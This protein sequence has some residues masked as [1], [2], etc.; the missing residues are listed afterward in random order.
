MVGCGGSNSDTSSIATVGSS[1][2]TTPVTLS[3]SAYIRQADAICGES[4]A[5]INAIVPGST[6]GEQA[7]STSQEAAIIRNEISSL[8][9]L[10][11][12]QG[13]SPAQFIAAMQGIS[14]QLNR[15]RLA[16]QRGDE[17]V[18]PSITAALDDAE[19]KAQSLG[20][21]YG[22]KNCGGTSAPSGSPVAGG[23]G[24]ST[25]TTP[26]T[27]TPTTITPTTTP[28]AVTPPSGGSTPITPTT[29]PTTTTPGGGVSPGGGGV[30][31]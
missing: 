25:A 5:A 19:A 21:S 22:F 24:G 1:T 18:L 13:A 20:A 31:P 16:L 14:T 6:S 8:H 29:T 17:G 10:G 3:K 12:P 11:T 4:N 7:A 2:S 28:T 23:S 15:K 9:T 27:V 26:T 30:G